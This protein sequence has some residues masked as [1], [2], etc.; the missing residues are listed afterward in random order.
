MYIEMNVESRVKKSNETKGVFD[1]EG[2]TFLSLV[3]VSN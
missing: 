2:T 1:E 3:M